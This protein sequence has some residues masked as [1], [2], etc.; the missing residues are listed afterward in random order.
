RPVQGAYTENH[1]SDPAMYQ[2]VR[3]S[4]HELARFEDVVQ[5]GRVRPG[6]AALWFSEAADVWDDNASPFDAAKRTL[7]VAVRHQPLPLDV[8]VEGDDLSGY[9]LLY[10]TD[11]HVS[12]SAS[13]AIASWVAAGGQLFATA[14]A[15]M[16]DELNQPNT[17]L[18][19]L[20]GVDPKQPQE[21]R[22]VIRREK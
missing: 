19:E 12:R 13:K 16:L 18:R 7:Y 15:G 9:K 3:K 4:L 17:A 10:L 8:L 11:R 1:T 6:V 14:G 5:D 22:E 20:L 21:A 2:E